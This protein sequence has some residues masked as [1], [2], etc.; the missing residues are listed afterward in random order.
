MNLFIAQMVSLITNYNDYISTGNIP[1]D[2]LESG[3]FDKC[4]TAGFI[5]IRNFVTRN[6]LNGDLVGANPLRWFKYLE[7]DGCLRLTLHFDSDRDKQNESE[8]I[9]PYVNGTLYIEAVYKS[10]SNFWHCLW[11]PKQHPSA[12]YAWDVRY[13][14]PFRFENTINR[15]V[16]FNPAAGR[17][18]DVLEKCMLFT[19]DND[20]LMWSQV[21]SIAIKVLE[22]TEPQEFFSKT[23]VINNDRH[24]LNTRRM[25]YSTL[26]AFMHPA[27][28]LWNIKYK[29][30]ED[31]A[32]LAKLRD[33]FYEALINGLVAAINSPI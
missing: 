19:M 8:T 5:L 15:A 33:E 20:F 9:S 26:A 23:G 17:L 30:E 25:I 3:V 28:E 24:S 18:K 1:R 11:Y 14:L 13:Y 21:C 12:D 16:N 7:K 6:H 31:K 32:I 27:E 29:R 4:E 10:Y 2:Y 22:S